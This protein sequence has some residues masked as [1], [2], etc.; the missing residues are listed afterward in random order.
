MKSLE[1]LAKVWEMERVVLTLLMNNSG[2]RRFYN[3]LGYTLDDTSP[4][5]SDETDYE[6]HSKIF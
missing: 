6:I 3:R 2:A 4:D 1:S 5:K